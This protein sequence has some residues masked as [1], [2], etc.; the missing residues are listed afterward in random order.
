MAIEAA[1]RGAAELEAWRSKFRIRE[2]ARADLVTDADTA[3]QKAVKE[4]LLAAYPEHNFLGEEEAYGRDIE[5]LR[6]AADAPP[7]WVCDPLD[8][9]GNYAHGVPAYCVNIA[10]VVK[11]E[12]VVAVTLDPRLNELFTATAGGGAF[13]NGEPIRVSTIA[14]LRDALLSTG[15]PSDY[16][17]QLRNLAAWQRVSKEAQALRRTGSSALNL[18]YLAAGRFDGY[19]CFDNWALGRPPRRAARPGSRRPSDRRGRECVRS[20]PHGYS[21]HERAVPCGGG[22]VVEV[23]VIAG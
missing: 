9:T 21:G 18:A 15:F 4:H 7:T 22:E 10:L 1:R 16:E 8:G 2:K 11:N 23:E 20:V 13:L 5:S 12:P 17:K 6:F 14:S 3:S 19:W